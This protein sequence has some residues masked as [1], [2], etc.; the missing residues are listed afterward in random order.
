MGCH[1]NC[2]TSYKM[3]HLFKTDIKGAGPK[4]IGLRESSI[5]VYICLNVQYD[6]YTPSCN[7]K[8]YVQEKDRI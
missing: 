2:R 6:V 4:D 5:Y 3:A 8:N 1:N 7:C